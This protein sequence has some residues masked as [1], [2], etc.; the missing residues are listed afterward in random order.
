MQSWL[1]PSPRKR[2]EEQIMWSHAGCSAA[3]G[4]SSPETQRVQSHC[5]LDNSESKCTV[6]INSDLH[7]YKTAGLLIPLLHRTSSAS[8]I[9][10]PRD[11]AK[12]QSVKICSNIHLS[13]TGNLPTT[14]GILIIYDNKGVILCSFK[15]AY[16]KNASYY[17]CTDINKPLVS[18]VNKPWQVCFKWV[19]YINPA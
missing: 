11:K 7:L 19:G 3:W 1:A 17:L 9:S 14:K 10:V 4:S 12:V 8:I 18:T 2:V 6:Y 13:C 15:G 5:Y 16:L